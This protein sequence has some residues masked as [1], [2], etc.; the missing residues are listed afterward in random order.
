MAEKRNSFN[1]M[2]STR[3]DRLMKLVTD[4]KTDFLLVS[5]GGEGFLE[6][7]LIEHIAKKST[8]SLTW[9]VTSAFWAKKNENAKKILKKIYCA[10]I[11][12]KKNNPS[13]KLCIRVSI[14]TPHINQLHDAQACKFQHIK[15]LVYFFE[16]THTLQKDF[17]LQLH[18]LEGEEALIESLRKMLNA[19]KLPPTSEIHTAEKFTEH[20]ITL[21]MPSGYCFEVTFAKLLL[22]D[23]AVDL[24]NEASLTDRISIWEKDAFINQK[25]LAGSHLNIDG[26]IGCDMLVVYDGRV[27]GGWQSEMPDVPINIDVD[28]YQEI[29]AKSF[30]DPGVLA[31]IERG[32]SYRFKIIDEVNKK[33]SLRAKAVNIRDYTSSILLE[34]D[35]TKLYYTVRA[36]QDFIA[37]GRLSSDSIN[38]PQPLAALIMTS[39]EDL[40]YLYNSAQYDI[41]RQFEETEPGF[42]E[43]SKA[44]LD[45]AQNLD[46]KALLKV[47]HNAAGSNW[48]LDKW[49]LLLKR[50]NNGWYKIH[51]WNKTELAHIHEIEQL[52]HQSLSNSA[53]IYE[54]L[55]R[56]N[57]HQPQDTSKNLTP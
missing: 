51:S 49:R 57:F 53:G 17:F 39:K 11:E 32:L 26:K 14:D 40:E 54:G 44:I 31:T 45:Y 42:S 52:I 35:T 13:R 3:V 38:W 15:N 56:F 29:I 23:T 12:C 22:S 37:E 8:A 46:S 36:I 19:E 43:L 2:T 28:S 20:A 27:A 1:T 25:G 50:I 21:K 30:N 16:N 4:S 55:S 48:N 18:S 5:G 34:E 7:D 41:I 6:L 33:A 24:R 10:H 47:A 9:L